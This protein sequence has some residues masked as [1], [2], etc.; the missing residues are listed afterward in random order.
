MPR[1]TPGAPP[2][3]CMEL[4]ALLKQIVTRIPDF[5]ISGEVHRLRS[6]WFDAIA[7]L[8]VQFT[9]EPGTVTR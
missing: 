1:S 7:K 8:P 5:R 2:I 9:P 6:I 4:H 3:R